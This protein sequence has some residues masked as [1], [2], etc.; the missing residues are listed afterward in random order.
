MKVRFCSRYEPFSSPAPSR[1]ALQQPHHS[2]KVFPA[3]GQSVSHL[4]SVRSVEASDGKPQVDLLWFGMRCCRWG[5]NL[6]C[7]TFGLSEA[8]WCTAD[9]PKWFIFGHIVRGCVHTRYRFREVGC[10]CLC[11]RNEGRGYCILTPPPEQGTTWTPAAAKCWRMP[12][13][14]TPRSQRSS[15]DVCGAPDHIPLVNVSTIR[16]TRSCPSKKRTLVPQAGDALEG[17]FKWV[18]GTCKRGWGAGHVLLATVIY[19]G[20]GSEAK[21][22]V[23]VPQM[24]LQF[25]APLIN[26]IF[27]LRKS[28]L[29]WVCVCV[30]VCVSDC[31]RTHRPPVSTARDGHCHAFAHML[32]VTVCAMVRFTTAS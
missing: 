4:P 7:C 14:T 29:V 5:W 20:G 19:T 23:C 1:T 31:S 27:S 2:V 3:N 6:L 32:P 15:L 9:I 22:K 10:P 26:A 16:V 8:R 24:D 18:A 13:C 30:C 25:R 28:F 11:F 12:C 21:V 17:S